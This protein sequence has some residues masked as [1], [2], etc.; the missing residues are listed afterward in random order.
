MVTVLEAQLT[1]S[2]PTAG[3]A[4]AGTAAGDVSRGSPANGDPAAGNLESTSCI[5]NSVLNV[6]AGRDIISPA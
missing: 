2:M 4:P 6:A 3:T 1:T 5:W